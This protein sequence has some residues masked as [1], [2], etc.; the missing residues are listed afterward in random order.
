M[1]KTVSIIIVF[2]PEIIDILIFWLAEQLVN[3][4]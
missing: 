1:G 4:I 2:K 3:S